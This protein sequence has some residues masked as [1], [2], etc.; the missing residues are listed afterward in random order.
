[1]A[2]F[3]NPRVQESQQ[4]KDQESRI[5]IFEGYLTFTSSS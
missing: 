3:N 4:D 2:T 1:M 5:L